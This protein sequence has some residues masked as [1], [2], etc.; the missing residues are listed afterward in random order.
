MDTPRPN[1]TPA[2][3]SPTQTVLRWLLGAA[4]LFTGTSHLMWARHEFAAQVP[5]SL[6]LP[7]DLVVVVSGVTE[8]ALG[9][10]LIGLWRYRTTVGW[11]VAAFFVAIFPG[12][13][14]Q[15]RNRIDA[16]GLNSDTARALRLVFQPVLVV[17]VLW[18]TGAWQAALARRR[19]PN[20]EKMVR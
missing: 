16:F 10:A 8:L 15:Y 2:R 13:I 14:A 6:P 12:N 7:V 20:A 19:T 9:G 11:I 18:A 4:L 3:T 5:R 1:H 17:W